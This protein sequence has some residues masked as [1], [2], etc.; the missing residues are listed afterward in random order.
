MLR[1][2]QAPVGPGPHLIRPASAPS[3]PAEPVAV[4][5]VSSAPEA[6]AKNPRWDLARAQYQ[7]LKEKIGQ[8]DA[9]AIEF[10]PHLMRLDDET[11]TLM[12][13]SFEVPGVADLFI[14]DLSIMYFE[15]RPYGLEE[16]MLT[17]GD[18]ALR[19]GRLR[20]DQEKVV[21]GK[22]EPLLP[23]SQ[24]GDV[25][26]S[27]IAKQRREYLEANWDQIESFDELEK[28]GLI[29]YR[30]RIGDNYN[31]SSNLWNALSPEHQQQTAVEAERRMAQL[32]PD[33]YPDFET[34]GLL[35][36]ATNDEGNDARYAPYL[37]HNL[38][39]GPFEYKYPDRIARIGLHSMDLY[40]AAVA[41][42]ATKTEAIRDGLV[43][44][45][46][47]FQ[48]EEIKEAQKDR[49]LQAWE[50]VDGPWV[51]DFEQKFKSPDT[52]Q[53]FCHM[54][55]DK[56]EAD[57]R[58]AE[59]L[60]DSLIEV[61]KNDDFDYMA[62]MELRKQTNGMNQDDLKRFLEKFEAAGEMMLG[63]TRQALGFTR[64]MAEEMQ[65][66]L[67]IDEAYDRVIR[68]RL[69]AED[70]KAEFDIEYEIDAIDIGGVLLPIQ[71]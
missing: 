60:V 70:P 55:A 47:A 2:I 3:G 30:C 40:V 37:R 67:S 62:F 43:T 1:Q 10:A 71:D 32:G 39:V 21:R 20:P 15:E 6:G 4:D 59:L 53:Q 45:G 54:F 25:I 46:L 13:K 11:A 50:D 65:Q 36:L 9:D 35:A 33:D 63:D 26:E 22:F 56:T 18:W 42:P 38:V 66:E 16:K 24:F 28:L 49:I 64:Q 48:D 5:Q 52:A 41:D 58:R 69:G 7:S 8:W 12:E 34:Q 19:T 61:D 29:A 68:K 17:I 57:W 44:S 31:Q 51:R 23:Q 14:S 27:C